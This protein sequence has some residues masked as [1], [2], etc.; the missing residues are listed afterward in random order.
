MITKY[1]NLIMITKYRYQICSLLVSVKAD[2]REK[3]ETG[4]KRIYFLFCLP[5]KREGICRFVSKK[6]YEMKLGKRSRFRA[7]FKSVRLRF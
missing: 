3:Y 4:D 2:K 7:W 6:H 5:R 1:S